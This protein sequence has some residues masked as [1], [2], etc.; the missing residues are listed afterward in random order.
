MLLLREDKFLQPGRIHRG[1]VAHLLKQV[2]IANQEQAGTED[3]CMYIT[4]LLWEGAWTAYHIHRSALGLQ[5]RL[6]KMG[7]RSACPCS[8]V[9]S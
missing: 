7:K 6:V 8:G 1:I 9:N 2:R 4:L 5:N 3:A